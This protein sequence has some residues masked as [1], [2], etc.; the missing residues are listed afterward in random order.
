MASS[1]VPSPYHSVSPYLVVEEVAPLIDFLKAAL[2][3]TE[4][5]AHRAP[6][7]TIAHAEVTIG[8]SVVMLGSARGSADLTRSLL[9]VYV[10]DADAVYA[11]AIKAGGTSIMEPEN[12]IYGDRAGAFKDPAGNSWWVATHLEDV[13]EAE[14]ERRSR[15]KFSAAAR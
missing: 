12:Q 8:D 10:A 3:A 11:A 14:L 9:Y 6:D 5:L 2:G 1:P 13:S 7:G 4:R 15:E